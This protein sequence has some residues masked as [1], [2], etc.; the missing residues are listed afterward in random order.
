MLRGNERP[1]L[2]VTEVIF[3]IADITLQ[4]LIR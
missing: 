3:V 1:D 4:A 2:Y